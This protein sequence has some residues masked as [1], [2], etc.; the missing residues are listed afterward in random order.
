MSLKSRLTL[1]ALLAT[2]SVSAAALPISF[3]D[4]YAPA[5]SYLSQGSSVRFTH[6]ILRQGFNPTTDTISSVTLAVTARDDGDSDTG[7]SYT[8]WCGRH[9]IFDS[10]HC[11]YGYVSGNPEYL[12]VE[13]DGSQLGSY[14]VD[15]QDFVRGVSVGALQLDGLLE[16]VLS[17]TAGDLYFMRST[18]TVMADRVAAVP[19]PATFSLLAVG[20]LAV[21][22][23]R[24]WKARDSA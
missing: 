19:E 21:V 23:L 18:L 15:Y 13:A 5:S 24:R 3:S 8:T 10:Y 7:Y 4:V 22:W 6:D 20:A 14:E 12:S 1:T 9:S 2:F 11:H 17:V 16:V